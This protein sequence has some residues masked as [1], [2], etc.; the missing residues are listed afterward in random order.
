MPLK[1]EHYQHLRSVF[2]DELQYNPKKRCNIEKLK[3][4]IAEKEH[5]ISYA[6]LSC[7]RATAL[8]ESGSIVAKQQTIPVSPVLL[9][10]MAPFYGWGSTTSRLEPLQGLLFTPI[11]DGTNACSFF[12]LGIIDSLE[13]INHKLVNDHAMTGEKN[14]IPV[15]QERVSLFIREFPKS[16]NRLRSVNPIWTGLLRGSSGPGGG[17]DSAPPQCLGLYLSVANKTWQIYKTKIKSLT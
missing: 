7:C 9:Y 16:S 14:I 1:A 12:S 3:E 15:L 8:E 11:N 13:I 4:M 6:P 17:A 2:R 10:F 5:N